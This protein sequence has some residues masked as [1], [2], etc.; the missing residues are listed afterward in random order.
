MWATAASQQILDCV[1]EM[2][3]DLVRCQYIGGQLYV[4]EYKELVRAD[5]Y[6][7]AQQNWLQH[8]Y[9]LLNSLRQE[10]VLGD[11]DFLLL[12]GDYPIRGAPIFCRWTL[13]KYGN[14]IVPPLPYWNPSSLPGPSAGP[15]WLDR[16]NA[17]VWRGTNTGFYEGWHLDLVRWMGRVPPGFRRRFVR[18]RAVE[19]SRRFA[20]LDAGITGWQQ[21]PKDRFW[22]EKM[23]GPT[24]EWV[25]RD[26]FAKH[27]FILSLDGNVAPESLLV[28]ISL[29]STILRQSSSYLFY[30]SDQL[31]PWVHYVPLRAE[32]SDIERRWQW[33]QRNLD[34]CRE[35]ADAAKE[36]F[37][38][39]SN[40]QIVRRFIAEQLIT[41]ARS[42]RG[43]VRL[44]PNA[45]PVEIM[46]DSNP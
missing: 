8:L 6:V 3:R 43:T 21:Q 32:L 45:K 4:C 15:G 14:Y 23:F 26:F 17:A 44:Y 10:K 35:I 28:Q 19:L 2:S 38:D 7:Q 16:H 9:P 30:G 42:F 13:P 18:L 36:A 25:D 5:W 27:R 11:L 31:R 24:H 40:D 29:G 37:D 41:Y 20:W 22:L 1:H 39:L 12:V 46:A 34:R 33:C